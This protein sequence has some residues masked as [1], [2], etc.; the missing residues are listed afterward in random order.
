MADIYMTDECYAENAELECDRLLNEAISVDTNNAEVLQQLANFKMNQQNPQEALRYLKE[1]KQIWSQKEPD[2][3]PSY[4]FRT[5]SA[6]FF[7]EL[8]EW[9]TAAEIL[10]NL[11]EEVDSNSEIWF[12]AGLSYSHFDP[13]EALTY[14][15]KCKELLAKEKCTDPEIIEKV[16]NCLASIHQKIAQLPP[17]TETDTPNPIDQQE[18]ND[19]E[20]DNDNNEESD[21]EMETDDDQ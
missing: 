1:S 3:W 7:I 6:K 21:K 17:K 16:E 11:I 18:D 19:D 9:E 4:E 15:A 13:E 20:E 14:I 5:Q 8:N 2:D 12:L 10:D